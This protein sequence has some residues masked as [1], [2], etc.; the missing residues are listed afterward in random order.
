MTNGFTN[1]QLALIEKV[2]WTIADKVEVR[3]LESAKNVEER[4][5]DS[6]QNAIALHAAT[7]PTARRVDDA[8]SR[9]RGGWSAVAAVFAAIASVVALI[10]GIM[11]LKR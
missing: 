8:L 6:R 1:E 2:A 10:V 11:A 7:C 9:A 5:L 3:L 4:L